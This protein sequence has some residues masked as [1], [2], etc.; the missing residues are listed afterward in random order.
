MFTSSLRQLITASHSTSPLL[1]SNLTRAVRSTMWRYWVVG[2]VLDV[3]VLAVG[4]A[5][6]AVVLVDVVVVV[7]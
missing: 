7:V 6:V 2:V 4:A 1:T 5:N 3:V